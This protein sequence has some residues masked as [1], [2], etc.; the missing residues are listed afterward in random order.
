[1]SETPR[2]GLDRPLPSSAVVG[3]MQGWF[4]YR[5]YPVFS[6]PWLLRRA[7]LFALPIGGLGLLTLLGTWATSEDLELGL[8]SGGMLFGS[9][10]LMSF[11]G[12]GFAAVVRYRGWPLR[13][14]RI[15]VVVAVLLGMAVSFFVDREVSARLEPMIEQ[16]LGETGMVTEAQKTQAE[17]VERSPLG[18][19]V[20]LLFL[21]GT[22]FLLGGGLALRGYFTEQRRVVDSA[23]EAELAEARLSAQQSALRLSLLQA[24][25]APHFLF[26]TLASIRALLRRDA[27]RAEATLDALV[28]HLR[29]C[30]PRLDVEGRVGLSTL[31]RELEACRSYLELMRLRLGGRLDYRIADPGPLADHPLLPM[32]LL[33]LVENAVKHGIEPLAG[34]GFI[35][36]EVQQADGA[37][38]LAVEDSGVGL[39]PGL[40]KGVGLANLRGQLRDRHGEAGRLELMPRAAGGGVR[41]EIRLPLAEGGA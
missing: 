13:R 4:G 18:L 38:L 36:V 14:E 30:M 2:Y 34:P 17:K 37:L 40:G 11:T 8:A 29:A 41:A 1:M 10:M 24:Q 22:Y 9:F 23:R 12:P 33:T 20:N 32:L 5:Q 19:T 21:A 27:D 3:G 28:D 25:I 35:A 31:G 15:G 26:N 7:A 39:Q 6:R 16:R